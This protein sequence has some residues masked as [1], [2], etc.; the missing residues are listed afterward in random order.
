MSFKMAEKATSGALSALAT[1]R[2]VLTVR[3]RLRGEVDIDALVAAGLRLGRN[4]YIAPWCIIDPGFAF[5]IEIGDGTVFGPRAH[6]LAH[7]ASMRRPLGLTRFAPVK[8]GPRVFIGADTLVLPGVTIG[9]DS[10][11]GAASVVSRDIPPGVLAYGNPARVV[12]P[13]Q[14]YLDRQEARMETGPRFTIADREDRR[15]WADIRRQ[16]GQGEGW[17]P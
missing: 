11:I 14:E 16:V 2:K 10:I 4:V 13:A 17:S 12:G 8:I 3:R 7:D 6:V 9:A 5:M 15:R 1:F